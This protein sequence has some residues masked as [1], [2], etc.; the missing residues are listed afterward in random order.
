MKKTLR[1]IKGIIAFCII[2]ADGFPRLDIIKTIYYNFRLFPFSIAKK[3]PIFIHSGVKI[4]DIGKVVID[5]KVTRGMISIGNYN[6]RAQGA[7]KIRNRG[8]II[9][10]GKVFIFG[11]V[12]LMNSGK[13]VFEGDDLLGENT[14]VIISRQLTIGKC[15]RIA[16]LCYIMDS[17]AHY[18]VNVQTGE[19]KDNTKEIIIGKCN[20]LANGTVVKKGTHT[21]DYTIVASANA[22]LSKDYTNLPPYSIIGGMPAKL[23]A[24]G[25]RRIYNKIEESR[26]EKIFNETKIQAVTIDLDNIDIDSYCTE[27]AI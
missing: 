5:G 22:L 17:D 26:L 14:V 2:S 15:T 18:M 20:W 4:Y 6:M 21:P 25:Y 23:I 8:E 19:I 10:K 16:S 7:T 1:R 9:F 27:N 12:N 13:I 3:L 24:S 11:G